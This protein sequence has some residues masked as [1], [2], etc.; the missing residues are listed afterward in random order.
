MS[1]GDQ[2]TFCD[3]FWPDMKWGYYN[4][5]QNATVQITLY[6]ADYPGQT[7]T[8]YGPYSVTQG[9]SFFSPRVRNRLISVGVGSSD[10][11]SF[12]RIGG[13]RYRYA[14]DGKF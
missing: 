11:G 6:G 3:Q 8:V 4:G 7:P 14:A 1:D 10:V 13:I 5:A 12:W 9:T 2:L